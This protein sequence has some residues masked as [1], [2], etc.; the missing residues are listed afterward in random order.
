[1]KLRHKFIT[2]AVLI[3]VLFLG[4]SILLIEQSRYLFL[5]I[6]VFIIASLVI[7]IHLYRAFL[8]PLN[9]LTAGIESIKD[10]EFNTTFLKTGQH[11]LDQLIDVY[12][13]MIEQLRNERVKQREQHFFLERLIEVTP[14]GV[15]IF[16]LDEKINTINPAAREMLGLQE[17]ETYGCSLDQFTDV[18]GGQL[19]GM[20]PGE[21]RIIRVSGI[22]TYRCRKSQFLDRGF[23]RHFI[24]IEE[25]TREI[26][27][28][29]KRAYD[30]VIRMMSHEVNNSVGAVNSILQ[31]S[32]NYKDQLTPEDRVDYENI[33]K[34]A[35]NRNINL[36]DFMAN[37]ANVVRI[38]PPKKVPYDV[39]KLLESVGILM[40]AECRERK[41]ELSWRLA[42]SPMV[43][44]IDVQQ[45][46][47]V[48]VNV[49]RNAIE[50]I[51]NGGKIEI[52]TEVSSS[53]LLKIIDSGE[54]ISA[55]ARPYLFTPF[56]STRKN[57]QGI[58]LT[59]IREILINHNFSFDLET[60]QP[61]RTEFQIDFS[62]AGVMT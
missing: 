30:K 16:D 7:T 25:L 40:D 54:G 19:A 26:I 51:D 24:V 3:H 35:I 33:I 46:E 29:Q 57:G 52:C 17:D 37:F 60:V 32:L 18:L 45:M 12:N 59:L 9:L 15:I 58:G 6:E 11:E 47:Q 27:A 5:I 61:G 31:S 1:M 28:S 49:F 21:V 43:V 53:P 20:N 13:Q 42:E 8:K 36:N 38:P 2:F 23:H 44:D 22:R 4:L 34:V 55:Q 10:R 62:D 39:H 48:L 56:Y 41:I 14:I 50:A